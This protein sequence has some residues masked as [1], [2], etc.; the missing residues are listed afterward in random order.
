M[1]ACKAGGTYPPLIWVGTIIW[2]GVSVLHI[3]GASPHIDSQLILCTP[4]LQAHD[5]VKISLKF[6]KQAHQHQRFLTS[7]PPSL[8]LLLLMAFCPKI[9][10]RS[11]LAFYTHA[12]T[13]AAQCPACRQFSHCRTTNYITIVTAQMLPLGYLRAS[14]TL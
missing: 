14:Q 10:C 8:L 9:L 6:L 13:K 3:L 1:Q 11:I 5:I 12:A 4:L 7:L 2:Q